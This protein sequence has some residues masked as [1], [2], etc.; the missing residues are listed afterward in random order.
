MR[1]M[2]FV[3]QLCIQDRQL[4]SFLL[5]LVLM[6]FLLP[7]QWLSAAMIAALFHECGHFLA[8]YLMGGTV[9]DIRLSGSGAMINASGL[10]P[11]PEVVCLLAGPLMGL[12]PALSIRIF[13]ALALCSVI[14]TLYNLLPIYP[15]DGGRIMRQII[16]LTGGSMRICRF[17]ELCAILLVLSLCVYL[18]LYFCVFYALFLVIFL[19]TKTPCKAKRD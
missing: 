13:P 8:V 5:S 3:K 6:V 2:P 17:I 1:W 16:Y 14:Q 12:L 10:A 19:F 4:L 7:I 9:H 18:R 11:V 15:L